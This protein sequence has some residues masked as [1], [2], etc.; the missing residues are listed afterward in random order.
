[1]IKEKLKFKS[2]DRVSIFNLQKN[3]QFNGKFATISP[4]GPM[5]KGS[6]VVRWSVDVSGSIYDLPEENLR[7][8]KA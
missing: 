1:M 7:M 5:V 4:F 8:I 6:R 2:G 3:P